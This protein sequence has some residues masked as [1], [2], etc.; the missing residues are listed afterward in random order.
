M[1]EY[2]KGRID[3]FHSDGYNLP[4]ISKTVNRT[5]GVIQNYINDRSGYGS[6][7]FRGRAKAL[8]ARGER[9]LGRAMSNSTMG[10]RRAKRELSKSSVH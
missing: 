1:S 9:R 5:R 4:Q 10:V 2:E 6:Q 7:R 8:S 3:A